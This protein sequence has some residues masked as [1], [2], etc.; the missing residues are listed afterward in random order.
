MVFAPGI[1]A[2]QTC[3][4]PKD[5]AVCGGMV[6]T[7]LF[8]LLLALLLLAC[9]KN[10][11]VTIAPGAGGSGGSGGSGS[12]AGGGAGAAGSGPVVPDCSGATRPAFEASSGDVAAFGLLGG[13]CFFIDR[14]E[15]TWGA[16]RKF[17]EA[18]KGKYTPD[19]RCAWN[20]D[21]LD[22]DAT[23][24]QEQVDGALP[25]TDDTFP[26]TCVDVCDAEAFCA[27]AGKRLCNHDKDAWKNGNNAAHDA[28]YAACSGG[29]AH[30]FPYDQNPAKG[31]C[32][33]PS[34]I[35]MSCPSG[36]PCQTT[37]VGALPGCADVEGR[38]VTD[39]SGNVAEWTGACDGNTGAGDF[40]R[41]AG[42][43]FLTNDPRCSASEELAR[44]THR[45]M[46]G[47]RCCADPGE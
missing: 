38:G 35:D 39:M 8:P 1:T 26:V 32:N 12:S 42:G 31:V 40:C 46:I 27:W 22:P 9:S 25:R 11:A 16:Y 4:A 2:R 41:T 29:D 34:K 37:P 17:L 24:L 28:W 6:V 18:W 36:K 20:K 23:C 14:T 10:T 15:V 33:E 45:P 3:L 30:A 44:K 5:E 21:T 43:S 13:G 7:R 19:G 47:F